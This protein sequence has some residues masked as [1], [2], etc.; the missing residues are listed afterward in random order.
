MEG[1]EIQGLSKRFGA[2]VVVDSVSLTV[3]EG[4]FF[5]LL[6]PSGGGKS[7]LLRLICG[8]EHADAGRIYL[9]GRDVSHLHPRE[10]NIGMV[11]QD[12]G[13]YPHMNVFQNIAYGLEARGMPRAETD[14]RVREAAAK[15][16]LTSLLQQ[17]VVDL[18]GGEQQRVALARALAKD[19]YLYLY[20]EPLSNLDPKLRAQARRDI[21]MVH[22]EK[23]RPSLYVTH[24]QTEALAFGDRI[25]IIAQGRLQQV[26]QAEELLNKPANLFVAGFIGSPPMNLTEVT[27]VREGDDCF[28]QGDGLR[29][30]LPQRWRQTLAGYA[31]DRV[32]LGIRPNALL[33]G[34]PA[35]AAATITAL[36]QDVEP[37]VGETVVTLQVGSSTHLSA[38]WQAVDEGLRSGQTMTVGAD[39]DQICLFDPETEQALCPQA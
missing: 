17:T 32:V 26:G 19:A 38:V 7:T 11:F 20:D 14:R 6:G 15:L 36:V 2:N 23:H 30:G 31:K 3:A 8:L 29:I 1:L 35:G 37:L 18:S 33:P 21:L 13:L 22:R 9:A 28:V 27:L 10:R 25:G 4:E 12:Y 5:V 24:D 16:G 39:L 34:Q